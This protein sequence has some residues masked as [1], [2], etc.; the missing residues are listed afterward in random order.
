ML[1]L[2]DAGAV[3]KSGLSAQVSLQ[4]SFQG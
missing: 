1:R 3:K 4:S 2:A